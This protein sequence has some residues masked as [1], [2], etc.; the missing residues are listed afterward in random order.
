MKLPLIPLAEP[1]KTEWSVRILKL[2]VALVESCWWL[3]SKDK[4][5]RDKYDGIKARAGLKRAI[6]TIARH[7]LLC[8]RRMLLDNQPYK[9]EPV[10][11]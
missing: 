1:L 10:T 4:A 6:V 7:L 3:I 5:M 8:I 11:Q 9:F 2:A